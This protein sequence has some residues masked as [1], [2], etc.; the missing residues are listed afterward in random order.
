VRE[1]AQDEP[2]WFAF[3]TNVWLGGDPRPRASRAWFVL[4]IAGC[5]V[6]A[7]FAWLVGFDAEPVV[8]GWGEV[9]RTLGFLPS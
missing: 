5:S 4:I 8:H 2:Q 3:R 6:C 9:S 7:A 1:Q